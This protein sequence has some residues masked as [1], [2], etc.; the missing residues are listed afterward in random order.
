MSPCSNCHSGEGRHVERRQLHGRTQFFQTAHGKTILGGYLSRVSS[1]RFAEMRSNTVIDALMILS[2]NR[3]IAPAHQDALLR[4]GANFVRSY[5]IGFVV[6]D[7][8]RA[9][10]ELREM[11]IRA[12]ALD[13]VETDG[14]FELYVPR[15]PVTA[16]SR[17]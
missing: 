4:G 2:E 9:S 10:D 3:T 12:L 17:P 6:I 1:Q 8:A 11:A 16:A 15:I 14:V 7:R 13:R 5:K